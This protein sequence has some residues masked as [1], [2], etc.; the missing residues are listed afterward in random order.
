MRNRVIPFIICAGDTGK[1]SYDR[2][3]HPEEYYE[4]NIT[5]GDNQLYLDGNYYINSQIFKPLNRILTNIKDVDI[6]KVGQFLDVNDKV[7]H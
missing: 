6:K 5:G 1:K 2:A 4:S 3:Y 7:V